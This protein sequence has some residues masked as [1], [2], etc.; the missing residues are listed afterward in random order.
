MRGYA[1][2]M[3]AC[4]MVVG[5]ATTKPSSRAEAYGRAELH[6]DLAT[7]FFDI[8]RVTIEAAGASH[9]L[10]KSSFDLTFDGTIALPPG[11]QTL[12][13]HAFAGHQPVGDKRLR[14]TAVRAPVTSSRST[15]PL[16]RSA[17]LGRSLSLGRSPPGHR[18][19]QLDG[20]ASTLVA[21]CFIRS[22]SGP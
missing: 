17:S 6:V 19:V 21:S 16:D 15:Q 12:V 5:C 11:M 2:S 9:D 7:S 4:L 8:T 3:I 14:H 18:R 20:R 10:V 22:R 1:G 13:A